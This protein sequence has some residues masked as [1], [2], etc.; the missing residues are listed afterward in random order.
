MVGQV[1]EILSEEVRTG[2]WREWLP[3]ERELAKAYQVSRFTLRRA[4]EVL[5][6]EGVIETLHGR[7][8]RATRAPRRQRPANNTTIGLLLPQEL[9]H[10]RYFATLVVD[11]LR[12]LLFE[13]GHGLIVHAHPQVAT[14]RPFELLKKLTQTQRHCCWLLIGCGPQTLGWFAENRVPAVV[15][16]TCDPSVGLPFVCLDNYALG[17]HAGLTLRQHGHR[18]IGALLTPSNPELRRGLANVLE[19]DSGRGG[20]TTISEVGDEPAS[21]VRAVDRMLKSADRP[22][23]LF[24]AESM[25]YL[26]V[27]SRLTQLGV[28]V[29]EEI[30]LL[31]RDDEPYLASML[32]APARYSKNPHTYAKLLLTPM[33]HLAEN[34]ALSK[35]GTYLTPEFV[36]GASLRRIG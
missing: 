9:D 22:T 2:R 28:R 15:S 6:R 3:E 29:P 5:R 13:R 30:S 1:S 34:D 23:A 32:P 33:L 26:T 20:N 4:L 18:R 31:C 24:V 16:G 7:G 14:R 35:P 25:M 12:T 36:A 19:P 11:D 17:R 10:F 27:F 21:V 8:T